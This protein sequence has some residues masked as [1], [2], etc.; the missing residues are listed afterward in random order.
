LATGLSAE[1]GARVTA[2]GARIAH[3]AG[4]GWFWA[5]ALVGAGLAL[6]F[7]SLGLLVLFPVAGAAAFLLSQ[8]RA[9][10]SVFGLLTGA[11]ALCL[12]VAYVQGSG[13]GDQHL[14]PRPWLFAGSVLVVGGIAGHRRANH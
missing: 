13:P 3:L 4:C 2:P 14:D 10:A 7:V 8:P 12:F 11:G 9:V 6:G 1:I 5:W